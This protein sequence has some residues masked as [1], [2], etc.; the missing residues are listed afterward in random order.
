MSC[1]QQ[2][3]GVVCIHSKALREGIG[4]FSARVHYR[5]GRIRS[6]IESI[7]LTARPERQRPETRLRSRARRV[8][9]AISSRKCFVID[10]FEVQHACLCSLHK[11]ELLWVVTWSLTWMCSV[12]NGQR[13][14]KSSG[15]GEV[16]REL[17]NES[18]CLLYRFSLRAFQSLCDCGL[19]QFGSLLR[20]RAR[21]RT[22]RRLL[23]AGCAKTCDEEALGIGGMVSE[24]PPAVVRSEDTMRCDIAV[25]TS[26]CT[27]SRLNPHAMELVSCS[28]TMDWEMKNVVDSSSFER[29]SV[30]SQNRKGQTQFKR[31]TS[32]RVRYPATSSHP[33]LPC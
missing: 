11:R 21:E 31:D 32:R 2:S 13:V 16:E 30:G 5:G 33:P 4:G 7:R 22:A 14:R 26:C 15:R 18:K 10:H 24:E 23:P 28:R 17:R 27:K 25:L 12:K 29:N 1:R 3:S 6:P 20:Y 19:N 9:A 8:S